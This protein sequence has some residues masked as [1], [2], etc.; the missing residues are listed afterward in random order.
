MP[1]N[2]VERIKYKA[3]QRMDDTTAAV[4]RKVKAGAEAAKR[5][6]KQAKDAASAKLKE[7]RSRSISQRFTCC[8]NLAYNNEA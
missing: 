1:I 6:M 5:K 3:K 2:K 7:V 4:K 8:W